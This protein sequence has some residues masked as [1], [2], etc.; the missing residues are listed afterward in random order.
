MF[1]AVIYVYP[2]MLIAVAVHEFVGHGLVSLLVGGQFRGVM[3]DFNGMGWAA[4]P[5]TSLIAEAV[6]LLG[7]PLSTSL[8]G[9]VLL[10]LAW[11]IGHRPYS[12]LPL[13]IV[14]AQCALEGTSYAFWNAVSVSLFGTMDGADISRLV[15]IFPVSLLPIM[16]LAG[17]LMI[18]SVWAVTAQ[19]LWLI[20]SHLH[21]GARLRGVG[22]WM[23]ILVVTLIP[24]SA[25]FLF[26]W[27]LL[28]PGMGPWPNVAAVALH[29]LA[30]ASLAFRRPVPKRVEVSYRSLA[31]SLCVGFGIF[32][33][34]TTAIGIWLRHGVMW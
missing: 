31:V 23:G 20:E 6:T 1:V 25:W 4:V 18:L 30:G 33:V 32:T 12:S 13:T 22:L 14:G 15:E 26:D 17:L 16:T 5:T 10:Y 8:T 21:D 28:L 34:L 24:S 2:G 29:L 9:L 27:D 19:L 11:I 7:G 3:L